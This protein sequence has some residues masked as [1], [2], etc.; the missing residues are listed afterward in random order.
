MAWK[1]TARRQSRRDQARRRAWNGHPGFRSREK[2]SAGLEVRPDQT[3]LATADSEAI[4]SAIPIDFRQSR[5]KR[6]PDEARKPAY[7]AAIR[8]GRHG[9]IEHWHVAVSLMLATGSSSAKTIDPLSTL[10]NLLATTGVT[11][12]LNR[13]GSPLHR[14]PPQRSD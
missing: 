2:A 11:L 4:A 1:V 7:S 12:A 3:A 14:C 10:S 13:K 9:T 5:I 6:M 8:T